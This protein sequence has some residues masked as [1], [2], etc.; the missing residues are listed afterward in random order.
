MFMK[1]KAKAVKAYACQMLVSFKTSLTYNKKIL[2]SRRTNASVA[3]Q[4]SS[5]ITQ[6][7]AGH[8]PMC[9]ANIQAWP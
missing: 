4:L 1:R 5:D 2:T 6:F 8:C 3:K 7:F 9:G